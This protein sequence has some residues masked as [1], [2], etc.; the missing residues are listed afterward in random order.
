MSATWQSVD[1]PPRA[2]I[3]PFGLLRAALRAVVLLTVLALGLTVL[4]ALRVIERAVFGRGRPVSPFI[5]QSVCRLAL[6]IMGVRMRLRGRVMAGRGA[7]VANHS[8]WLD[9]FALNAQTRVTFVSKAEVA[10]WAGIGWLARATGT[11]FIRRD[12]HAAAAQVAAFRE[13]L[14]AGHKLVFFPEGTSTDGRQVL[15]FKPT[16]FAAFIDEGLPADL[17]IQPISLVWTAPPGQDARF[18]GWWGAMDFAPHLVRV[19][20]AF[21]QGTVTLICHPPISV[22]ALPDRKALARAAE[23]AVRA[24]HAVGHSIAA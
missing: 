17:A 7:I 22:T 3:G 15:P 9:I 12:R 24:G 19:L 6:A 10:G 8:S 20:A 14:A 5:T 1:P 2:V 13:R 16:L 4:L 21:P 18:Y 11:L 23:Q